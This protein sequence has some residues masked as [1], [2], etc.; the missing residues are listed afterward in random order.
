[1]ILFDYTVGEILE[2]HEIY[3]ERARVDFERSVW[4]FFQSHKSAYDY[5]SHQSI[6]HTL[7]ESEIALTGVV[8]TILKLYPSC[9][10][11][12]D[13]PAFDIAVLDSIMV[14]NG[15]TPTSYRTSPARL[16]STTEHVY[17]KP[18]CVST[19]KLFATQII[20]LPIHLK[21]LSAALYSYRFAHLHTPL[22]DC[23]CIVSEFL[24]L[25]SFPRRKKRSDVSRANLT[26][27]HELLRKKL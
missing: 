12:S 25:A 22:Y 20:T 13:H 9:R 6:G 2:V 23:S 11:I 7:S 3:V 10:I 5:L 26:T 21:R 18:L 16:G 14:T 27:S 15:Y 1:M 4:E 17:V 19:L 24:C 8:D